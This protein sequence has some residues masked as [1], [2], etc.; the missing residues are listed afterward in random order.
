VKPDVWFQA[1]VCSSVLFD[2]KDPMSVRCQPQILT[3]SSEE[4]VH[5]RPLKLAEG[6]SYRKGRQNQIEIG[7]PI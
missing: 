7:D 1:M 2:S 3:F 6:A 5:G 4:I